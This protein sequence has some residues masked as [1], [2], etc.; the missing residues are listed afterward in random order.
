MLSYDTYES[1]ENDAYEN[2]NSYHVSATLTN[3]IGTHVHIEPTIEDSEA[4]V[5]TYADVTPLTSAELETLFDRGFDLVAFALGE[6]EH[7]WL[8]D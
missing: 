4:G 7:D 1:V 8:K 6:S 3:L 5:V 2:A